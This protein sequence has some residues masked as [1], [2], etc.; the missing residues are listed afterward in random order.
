MILITAGTVRLFAVRSGMGEAGDKVNSLSLEIYSL[1][2]SGSAS[3]PVNA[4]IWQRR[5]PI[6]AQLN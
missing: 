6:V 4:F 5:N 2:M 1:V 3:F